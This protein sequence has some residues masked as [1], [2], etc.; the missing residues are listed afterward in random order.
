MNF[1]ACGMNGSQGQGNFVF[2]VHGPSDNLSRI[3]LF[4]LY[5][6]Y[7]IINEML[8]YEDELAA[9]ESGADR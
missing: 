5:E 9:K 2:P 6:Q 4:R 1:S 3:D 7:L 8:L